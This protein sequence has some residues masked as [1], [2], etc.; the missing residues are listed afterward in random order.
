MRP[1]TIEGNWHLIKQRLKQQ[2][3]ALSD[4]DLQAVEGPKAALIEKLQAR[5]GLSRE[6]ILGLLSTS[7][8]ANEVV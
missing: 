2:L 5:T 3:P 1:S 4:E 7:G 8:Y 6:A